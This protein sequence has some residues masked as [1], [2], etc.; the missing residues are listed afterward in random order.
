MNPLQ[1]RWSSGVRPYP[2]VSS[3][4]RRGAGTGLSGALKDARGRPALE[5]VPRRAGGHRL[6]GRFR[7][8]CFGQGRNGRRMVRNEEGKI[9]RLIAA[10]TRGSRLDGASL[11]AAGRQQPCIAAAGPAARRERPWCACPSGDLFRRRAGDRLFVARTEGDLAF[12]RHELTGEERKHQEKGAEETPLPFRRA[13][14]LPVRHAICPSLPRHRPK[15]RAKKHRCPLKSTP[16]PP[17]RP[18]RN[19]AALAIDVSDVAYSS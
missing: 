4:R 18:P 16:K 17:N 8:K 6:G 1:L 19:P 10:S 3:K 13:A 7:D 14:V 5:V 15:H 2:P 12:E 11:G 9:I